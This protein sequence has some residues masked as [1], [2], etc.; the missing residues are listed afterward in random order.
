[1]N[2]DANV[3]AFD[4]ALFDKKNTYALSGNARYSKIFGNNPYDGY[5]TQLQ[6]RKIG[7]NLQFVTRV[8]IESDRYDP[9]DLGF[10]LRANKVNYFGS[11]T[12]NQFV[13]KGSFLTYNYSLSVRYN[14][15]YKPYA[16][17]RFEPRFTAF[18][19]FKNF[20]DV[21]LTAGILPKGENDY[22]ELRTPG[23]FVNKPGYWFNVLK[24][25]SDSRKKLFYNYHYQWGWGKGSGYPFSYYLA[26]MGFRYRFGEKF[27]MELSSERNEEYGQVG[28][29]FAREINN[30]PIVGRRTYIDVNSILTGQYNFTSRLNLSFRGR[31]YWSRVTYRSLHNASAT[32]GK[33]IPRAFTTAIPDPNENFNVFNIDAFLTWDFRLGSRIILGWKNFLGDDEFVDGLANRK[34]LNN[35]GES[36]GLNHGNEFTLRF[37]YFLD[38]N[39]LRKK[40]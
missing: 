16:F 32:T 3:S 21:T 34:Y 26:S 30:E 12:Y 13:P 24:G 15:L 36:F 14:W 25:S 9:N 22:F 23:R 40:R 38:Y 29:V 37:I 4:F 11:L 33:L 35:L 7:G 8:N 18:W 5:N 19:V 17:T 39:Q 31:H 20:W 27:T 10:L 2:R 1:M 6:F 28:Y